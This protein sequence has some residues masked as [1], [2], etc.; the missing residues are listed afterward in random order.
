PSVLDLPL[1]DKIAHIRA[2]RQAK[3][4]TVLTQEEVQ[5]LLQKMDG[6]HALMAK[7]LYGSGLRLMECIR[8]RIQDIDFGQNKIFVRGGKG[9]K[10]R[11]TLLPH[12]ISP[13]LASHVADVVQLHGR[14][15]KAGFGQVHI[16]EALSRKWPKAAL[17]T[18]KTYFAVQVRNTHI[19]TI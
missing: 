15:K 1:K 19:L 3:P 11:V 17:E 7:L 13:L 12:N 8:L 5:R 9:G 6:T 14:D 4:P 18:T 2:K 10:D 16:S